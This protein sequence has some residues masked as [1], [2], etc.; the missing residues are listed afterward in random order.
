MYLL[1]LVQCLRSERSDGCQSVIHH[2]NS[3]PLN[4]QSAV[5]CTERGTERGPVGHLSRYFAIRALDTVNRFESNVK[6]FMKPFDGRFEGLSN[7]TMQSGFVRRRNQTC[8]ADKL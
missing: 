1:G 3:E 2:S 6:Y 5:E 8:H 7:G 4:D